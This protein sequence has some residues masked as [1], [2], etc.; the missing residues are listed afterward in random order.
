MPSCLSKVVFVDAE[1]SV[2]Q[3]CRS[4]ESWQSAVMSMSAGQVDKCHAAHASNLVSQ[5]DCS[6]AAAAV[7]CQRLQLSMW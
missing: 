5:V 4:V 1:L 2:K 7:G 6:S 3:R